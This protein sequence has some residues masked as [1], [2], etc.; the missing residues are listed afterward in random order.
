MN[1]Y[2]VFVAWA[3]CLTN[4]NLVR[5]AHAALECAA[6]REYPFVAPFR[7]KLKAVSEGLWCDIS[8]EI[9][10][11]L[12]VLDNLWANPIAREKA[13]VEAAQWLRS[14]FKQ[15]RECKN[16]SRRKWALG[17]LRG[18][19][20]A[21]TES[22]TSQ[23]CQLHDL[24]RSFAGMCGEEGLSDWELDALS[25]A[26]PSV[27]TPGYDRLYL[28]HDQRQ[29]WLRVEREL[30]ANN[31][32]ADQLP[33]CL[34][35]AMRFC[36]HAPTLNRILRRLSDKKQFDSAVVSLTQRLCP[37]DDGIEA[38]RLLKD[39]GPQFLRTAS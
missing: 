24:W 29:E 15:H 2:L 14:F 16:G 33:G 13:A 7:A 17:Y 26:K 32:P 12:E 8:V 38:L 21:L 23:S 30:D 4:V 20:I 5:L 10:K 39:L 6:E 28:L 19:L 36:P 31:L 11:R 22:C 37:L 27:E 18:L 3:K 35:L 1:S 9:P 25:I 34:A